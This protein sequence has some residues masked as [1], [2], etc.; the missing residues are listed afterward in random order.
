MKYQVSSVSDHHFLI[1]FIRL[2]CR[3]EQCFLKITE[4]EL[5]SFLSQ[6]QASLAMISPRVK[7]VYCICKIIT[8]DHTPSTTLW[9][10]LLYWLTN[11]LF[12]LQPYTYP[13]YKSQ[14]NPHLTM[15]GK[16]GFQSACWQWVRNSWSK[17][18][19]DGFSYQAD[20]NT[21]QHSA[22]QLSVSA[23][24]EFQLWDSMT[25]T[26]AAGKVQAKRMWSH[27]W[28][29]APWST[30]PL[31]TAV[32]CLGQLCFCTRDICVHQLSSQ[33]RWPSSW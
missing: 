24:S 19:V 3:R 13:A 15:T 8:M 16:Q 25:R 9:W 20:V 22:N 29:K 28:L 18:A 30:S 33:P 11:R 26:K 6:F 1:T 31:H 7:G 12:Q 27:K 4:K 14:N 21:E 23:C 5:T 2:L 10:A 17:G 32:L